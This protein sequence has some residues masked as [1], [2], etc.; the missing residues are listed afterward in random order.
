MT[1]MLANTVGSRTT[2]A[3]SRLAASGEHKQISNY[4]PE[5]ATYMSV[6]SASV[7]SLDTIRRAEEV[8]YVEM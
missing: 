8:S 2:A 7:N 6:P 4:S 5:L 3:L 1:D